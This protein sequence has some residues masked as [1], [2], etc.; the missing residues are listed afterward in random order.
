MHWTKLG[1]IDIPKSD[2]PSMISHWATPVAIPLEGDLFR[3]LYTTRDK[4]NRG[5]IAY[6]DIELNDAG[7][8][9]VATCDSP[10]LSPDEPGLFDDSGCSVGCCLIHNGL[11]YLY[12][13]GWNLGVTVPWRNSVGLAIGDLKTMEF[14]RH[15]QAPVLDRSQVDPFT[16]SFPWVIKEPNGFRMYYGSNLEWGEQADRHHVIK[17]ATSEDGLSWIP[18][19]KVSLGLEGDNRL[20][21]VRPCVVKD[22][23]HYRMWYSHR[24]DAYRIGYAESSDGD[25]WISKDSEVGIDVSPEGWDSDTL[26]HAHVFKHRDSWRMLYN[27]N[28][29]GLTGIGYAIAHH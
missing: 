5:H 27:G 22:K 9:V 12:Y 8:R 24:G 29:F 26:S 1:L 11:I 4:E 19:G 3:I 25:Q 17:T 10:I 15:S 20:A 2:H 6:S 14:K 21:V 16:L 13:L 18:S 7:A 28:Q 23:D